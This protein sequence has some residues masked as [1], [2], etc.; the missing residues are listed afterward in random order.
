MMPI[1][2][3][4]IGSIRLYVG[5]METSQSVWSGVH[6]IRCIGSAALSM[7]MVANGNVDA[8]FENN[9]HCWDIAAG[10]VI[11][12]EAGGATLFPTGEL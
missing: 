2:S 11:V 5:D 3:L 12:R 1:V 10:V 7:C 8:F 6:R 9:I 4:M